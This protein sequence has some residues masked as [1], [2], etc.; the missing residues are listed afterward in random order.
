MDVSHMSHDTEYQ[1]FFE[2][3]ELEIQKSCK[4]YLKK[5]IYAFI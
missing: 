2:Y 5:N 3:C 4:N 1:T